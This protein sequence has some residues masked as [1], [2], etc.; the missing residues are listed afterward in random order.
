ML[1]QLPLLVG[2]GACERLVEDICAAQVV[3]ASRRQRM[4]WRPSVPAAPG[5]AML[6]AHVGCGPPVRGGWG[7]RTF[8][9]QV[10]GRPNFFG[11]CVRW[12]QCFARIEELRWERIF[13]EIGPTVGCDDAS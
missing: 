12:Q 6:V 1:G 2:L 8:A 5:A 3:V 10:H 9:P 4:A 13:K 11:K 7:E